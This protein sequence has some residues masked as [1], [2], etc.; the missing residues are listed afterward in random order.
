MTFE[1]KSNV[2]LII[3]IPIFYI[4]FLCALH[5]VACRAP[6]FVPYICYL[7]LPSLLLE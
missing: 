7:H 5:W 2:I 4:S 3:F 6:V 1:Y